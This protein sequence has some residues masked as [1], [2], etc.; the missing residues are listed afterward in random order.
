MFL[1]SKGWTCRALSVSYW[2]I[3]LM[4]LGQ[5]GRVKRCL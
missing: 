5:C 1:A 4:N 2:K 3:P